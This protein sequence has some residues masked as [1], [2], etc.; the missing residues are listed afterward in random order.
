[1]AT[2]RKREATKAPSEEEWG[3]QKDMLREL[4]FGSTL[5]ELMKRMENEHMFIAS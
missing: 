3:A 1:M 4:Y 5:P 2:K